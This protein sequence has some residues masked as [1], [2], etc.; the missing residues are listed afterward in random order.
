MPGPE[1]SNSR[2][3]ERLDRALT[4]VGLDRER[5]ASTRGG[6]SRSRLLSLSLRKFP[7][8]CR[9][10]GLSLSARSTSSCPRTTP[11][12]PLGCSVGLPSISFSLSFSGSSHARLPVRTRIYHCNI[13]DS[14]A[15][16]LDI[17]KHQWS[18]ALSILKVVLSL[19]SLLT[20]PNPSAPLSVLVF[21][22]NI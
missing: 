20:D 19:S 1:V 8:I 4:R 10:E 3:C 18:P 17:L 9:T 14:G 12:P 7:L 22:R 21:F 5:G 6:R 2:L 15:I 16:C 11:S 13:A